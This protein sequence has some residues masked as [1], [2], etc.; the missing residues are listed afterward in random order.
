MIYDISIGQDT[1]CE[2]AHSMIVEWRTYNLNQF[3]VANCH[4]E[5]FLRKI[6]ENANERCR[7]SIS[8]TISP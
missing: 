5:K 8:P 7:F 2:Q 6:W 1:S 3:L 4:L